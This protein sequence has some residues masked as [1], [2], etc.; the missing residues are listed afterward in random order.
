MDAMSM[1]QEQILDH[2]QNPRNHGTLDEP[3]TIR[4]EEYNPLC[5]DRLVLE[6][7]VVDD[8]VEAVRFRGHGC[9]ISQA[10]MSMLSEEIVGKSVDELKQLQKQDVLDLLGIPLSPARLKC[11]LLSLKAVKA[12]V[13]GVPQ[14]DI[15]ED[16]E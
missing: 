15:D 8:K 16:D 3:V 14:Y 13:Y 1:Y 7:R 2:Y 6:M 5:G 11:A 10:A 9:A 4:R 12:G